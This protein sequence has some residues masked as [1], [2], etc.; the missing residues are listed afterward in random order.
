MTSSTFGRTNTSVTKMSSR[1]LTTSAAN[2]NRFGG[3]VLLPEREN[4][5]LGADPFHKKVAVYLRDNLLAASLNPQAY[6]RNPGFKAS[7]ERSGLPF[8]PAGDDF[9]KD[10]LDARQEL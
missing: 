10:D 5:A 7:I 3:L 8:E 6:E 9:G 1:T 2:R 4:R